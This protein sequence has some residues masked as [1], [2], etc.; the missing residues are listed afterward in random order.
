MIYLDNSSTTPPDKAAIDA[1]NREI[2][3]FGNP[4]SP[5]FM[6]MNASALLK[7]ARQNI[8]SAIKCEAGEF[9]FTSCGSESNNAAILGLAMKNAKHSKRIVTTDSEH[10]SV[11]EPLLSLEKQGFEIVRLSTK[12]GEID[13]CELSKALSEKTA[14]VTIM[15]GNNE[16]GAIYDLKMIREEIDE[17]K[18]GAFF[19]SDCVQSFMKVGVNFSKYVDAAS[20]SAHKIGGIKGCG[21]LYLNK[22]I[23][24]EPFIK[25]GGQEKGFRSGTENTIGIAAFS[26]AVSA[27]NKD[28]KARNEHISTLK[29]YLTE[30]L[31]TR[32]GEG[33]V[34]N[35]PQNSLCSVLNFSIPGIK[36]ETV[37]NYLSAKG[38]CV[39]ASSACSTRAKEN[40]VLFAFGLSRE[41]SESA[42][43]VG[44][45]YFNTKDEI[46]LFVDNIDEISKKLLK[47][48]K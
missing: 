17:S 11:A 14:L 23:K 39:S 35:S 12:R 19:H 9:Y 47:I 45:S 29:N 13:I 7:E 20:V 16:T 28:K 44:I 21:G 2:E 32:L 36:S 34:I 10:P 22:N 46:D 6:G 1:I 3:N 38:I 15:Q 24:I 33:V 31:L 8:A 27:W 18:C 30:S 4:S 37:I 26:A 40:P 25:G 42:I 5:H 41:L 43:R 48:K